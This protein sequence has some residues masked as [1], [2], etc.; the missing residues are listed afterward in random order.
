VISGAL[1]L[2]AFAVLVVWIMSVLGIGEQ[3]FNLFIGIFGAPIIW[4]SRR[5]STG[6][7]E[8]SIRTLTPGVPAPPPAP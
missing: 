7:R 8:R 3:F 1:G 4:L 6:R 2:I 5:I